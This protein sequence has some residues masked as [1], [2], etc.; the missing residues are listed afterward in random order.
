MEIS[1]DFN[2]DDASALPGISF[3]F[4]LSSSTSPRLSSKSNIHCLVRRLRRK[5]TQTLF[6]FS[7]SILRVP[8]MK[9]QFPTASYDLLF[10]LGSNGQR[11]VL[12]K[13][14]RGE[15]KSS[16]PSTNNQGCHF[17]GR[18]LKIIREGTSRTAT[19]IEA[20]ICIYGCFYPHFPRKCEAESELT[21]TSPGQHRQ[22]SY[23]G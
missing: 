14:L 12:H 11:R 23:S 6:S 20:A 16:L 22:S 4:N 8:W 18:Q 19:D 5:K 21:S 10:R 1:L 3:C 13:S 15:Y 7:C 9:A 2:I 17:A